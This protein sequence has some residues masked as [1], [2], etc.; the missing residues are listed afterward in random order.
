MIGDSARADVIGKSTR[1]PARQCLR[2]VRIFLICADPY[3]PGKPAN[4]IVAFTGCGKMRIADHCHSANKGGERV[5]VR[6]LIPGMWITV[7]GR[8]ATC[9]NQTVFLWAAAWMSFRAVLFR[10]EESAFCRPAQR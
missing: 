3:S 1:N 8:D 4:T 10:E 5:C 7:A 6:A 9:K 2:R